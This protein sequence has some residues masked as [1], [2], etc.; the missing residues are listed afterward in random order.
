M[1]E[2]N[3][4]TRVEEIDYLRVKY[5]KVIASKDHVTPEIYDFIQDN[6]ELIIKYDSRM[7]LRIRNLILETGQPEIQLD[8]LSF[9]E[10]RQL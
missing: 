5:G 9:G 8:G 2:S 7:K 4:Y 10:F 6:K 3:F 1:Q